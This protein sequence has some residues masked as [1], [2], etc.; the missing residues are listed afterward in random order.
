MSDPV[1]VHADGTD[2][3]HAGPVLR[4]VEDAGGPACSAGMDVTAVRLG[5]ATVS[6]GDACASFRSLARTLAQAMGP[7]VAGFAETAQMLTRDPAVR[8]LAAAAEVI[9]EERAKELGG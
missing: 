8:A 6:I 1:L 7:L 5:D 3:H 2:C 4:T 9:C